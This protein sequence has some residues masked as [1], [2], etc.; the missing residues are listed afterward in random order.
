MRPITDALELLTAQHEE[1]DEL[2]VRAQQSRDAAVF[3][4]L[5]DKLVAH[6][7]LEQEMFYPVV[8]D[9][10]SHDVFDELLHEHVAIKCL[11]GELVRCG[12]GDPALGQMSAQLTALFQGHRAWQEEQLFE[13]VAE[14]MSDEALAILCRRLQAA[15]RVAVAA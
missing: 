15:E 1:I 8:T 13:V 5:A 3:D 9:L 6:L 11:A 4:E 2:F 12:N 10:I 14:T 7:T